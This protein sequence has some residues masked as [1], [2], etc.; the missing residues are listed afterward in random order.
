MS[1]NLSREADALTYLH[2]D[3]RLNGT[4]FSDKIYIFGETFKKPDPS[5]VGLNYYLID[6]YVVGTEMDLSD[7]SDVISY[8]Y[9]KNSEK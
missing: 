8:K 6:G 5:L 1:R 9:N 7:Y 3:E 2:F 4:R